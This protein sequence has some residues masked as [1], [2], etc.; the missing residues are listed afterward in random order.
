MI[1]RNFFLN[2]RLECDVAVVVEIVVSAV[3]VTAAAVDLHRRQMMNI[4]IRPNQIW[5][6]LSS[7]DCSWSLTKKKMMTTKMMT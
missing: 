1:E 3:V 4:P 2:Y 6:V 5:T 7:P